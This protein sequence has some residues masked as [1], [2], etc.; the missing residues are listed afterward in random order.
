MESFLL[1][2]PSGMRVRHLVDE[3]SVELSGIIFLHHELSIAQVKSFVGIGNRHWLLLRL[4]VHHV[5]GSSVGVRTASL[6]HY[7]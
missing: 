3:R 7:V 2:L 5:L 1:T 6:C 4:L